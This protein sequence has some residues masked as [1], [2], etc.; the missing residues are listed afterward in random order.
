M[1]ENVLS[2][3]RLSTPSQNQG[4]IVGGKNVPRYSNAEN[5]DMKVELDD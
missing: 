1:E 5:A 3:N 4:F 2:P